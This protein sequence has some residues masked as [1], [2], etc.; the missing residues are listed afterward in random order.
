MFRNGTMWKGIVHKTCISRVH[1]SA[2]LHTEGGDVIRLANP[3]R[4]A[5]LWSP[6]LTALIRLLCGVQAWAALLWILRCF[7]LSLH[8]PTLLLYFHSVERT[9]FPD[10]L[11]ESIGISCL[12][13]AAP[14]HHNTEDDCVSGH[15][16]AVFTRARRFPGQL[17]RLKPHGTV[18]AFI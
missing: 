6:Q 13:P 5:L 14:S 2:P 17:E 16:M 10:E 15:Q 11:V 18:R 9:S 1:L 8:S 7:S 4:K 3:G 12:P